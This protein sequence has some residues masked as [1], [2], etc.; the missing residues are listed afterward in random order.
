[1]KAIILEDEQLA[2]NRLKRMINEVAPDIKV[3]ATFE[4]IE[5]TAAYLLNNTDT[6]L[7]FLDIHVADGNSFE[8]F[9]IM[10]VKSNVIFTTAYDQYAIDAFRTNAI[11]YLLKP[12]KKDQLAEAIAKAKPV[13]RNLLTGFPSRYKKRIVIQFMSKLH[14]IKTE[15]I[16]YI[17]SKN[18]VSYFY[19]K[20]GQRYPSDFK[21]Q[22][23]EELLDPQSFFRANRQFIIN[24]DAV[25][26][27]AKHQASRV[28]ITLVPPIDENI[29]ISTDKTPIFKEWLER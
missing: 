23:L 14:S 13:T 21:L 8:L 2:A 12:L 25:V 17:F 5:D 20:E 15:D 28:K 19:T 24:I 22:D 9:R 1:M 16:A 3:I 4:T 6:D 29:V 7:V 18:K 10:D 27:I 11:D 26:G